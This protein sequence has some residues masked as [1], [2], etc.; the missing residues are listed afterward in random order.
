MAT[1]DII[2]I[3]L[4]LTH[5]TSLT[6]WIGVMIFNIVI[7]FPMQKQRANSLG[8][9]AYS[10]SDQATRA[11]GWLY[12]LILL[13]LLSGFGLVYMSDMAYGQSFIIGKLVLLL[14]MLF[15]HLYA[16]TRLWP[17]IAFALDG[18]LK[19]LIN[20]Y[21]ITIVSSLT[22]GMAASAYSFA[23]RL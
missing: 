10:L 18:E 20:A 16:T 4:Y 5:F 17:K 21:T 14:M 15:V 22:L 8:E 13:T 3:L 7:N 9:Y 11:A 2:K 6:V 12:L 23:L 1:T 19:K